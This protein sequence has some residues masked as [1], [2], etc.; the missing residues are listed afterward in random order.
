MLFPPLLVSSDQCERNLK[1]ISKQ[2][3]PLVSNTLTY[4]LLLLL[5]TTLGLSSYL[6]G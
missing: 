4:T 1:L 2:N 3:I 5:R 6:C